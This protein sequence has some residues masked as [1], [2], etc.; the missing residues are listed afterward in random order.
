MHRAMLRGLT[1]NQVCNNE[2]SSGPTAA[3]ACG[4]FT[5][6]TLDQVLNL[7]QS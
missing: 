2:Q 5:A 7:G 3:S 1:M 4:L 6:K